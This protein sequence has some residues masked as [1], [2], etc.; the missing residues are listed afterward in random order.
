MTRISTINSHQHVDDA[1][2]KLIHPTAQRGRHQAEDTADQ[3]G[4]HGCRK[5][6]TDGVAGAVDQ[7]GQHVPAQIVGAEHETLAPELVGRSDDF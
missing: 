3:K 2:E 5:G 6:D 4:E 7:T 1:A